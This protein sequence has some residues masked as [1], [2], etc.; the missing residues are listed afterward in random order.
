MFPN[1][2]LAHLSSVRSC[3]SSTMMCV[4]PL[5]SA[6]PS[7]LLS[8]TP[9]VQYS[10]LVADVWPHKEVYKGQQLSV[11]LVQS[12]DKHRL[13]CFP[14]PGRFPSGS[15]SPQNFP[16]AR[17]AP[18][19]PSGPRRWR[20][21]ASAAYKEYWQ[22]CRLGRSAWRPRWTAGSGWSSHTCGDVTIPVIHFQLQLL[23]PGLKL[24]FTSKRN[25]F[26]W[27]FNVFPQV[28]KTLV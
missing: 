13:K 7:S 16:A 24:T 3:T 6:S 22:P 20:I 9:V 2:S 4:T 17:P 15:G 1:S 21:C 26:Y 14:L 18:V 25:M 27:A 19:Q 8:R 11:L 10:S 5:S 28:K 12:K 23:Y